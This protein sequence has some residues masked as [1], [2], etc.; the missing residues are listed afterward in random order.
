ML[1]G[2]PADVE[3][4]EVFL[5]GSAV[6]LALVVQLEKVHVQAAWPERGPL[7]AGQG[8]AGCEPPRALLV[9]HVGSRCR[10]PFGHHHH[11]IV[12]ERENVLVV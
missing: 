8:G 5:V 2:A 4:A 1:L 3:E 10:I 11:S 7:G 9:S 12:K 6:L